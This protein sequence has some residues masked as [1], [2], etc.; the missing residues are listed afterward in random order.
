VVT[1]LRDVMLCNLD[2][3]QCFGETCLFCDD[4]DGG[5]RFLTNMS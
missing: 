3:D 1:G 5:N 2:L 4:D